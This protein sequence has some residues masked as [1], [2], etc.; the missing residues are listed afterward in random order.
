MS[1]IG[2]GIWA[3]QQAEI[4][5]LSDGEVR[6]LRQDVDKVLSPL[7]AMVVEEY[8][9][10]V[11]AA[12]AGLLAA[13]ASS[14]A[15]QTVLAAG[16]LAGGVAALLADGRNVTFTTAGATPAD[17]PATALITGTNMDGA[18]QTE[19]VNIAQTATIANGV[20]AFKTITSVVYSAGDGAA[21]TVS[22]GFGLKFGL[23]K[24]P[25]ARA[26]LT[27]AIRE[28]EV[29]VLVTTGTLDATNRTYLPATA[30][31]GTRDYCIYY[32]YDATTT[33]DG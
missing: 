27:S 28:I 21:A 12:A 15:V 20:K 14:I 24:K 23:G 7:A 19:T 26:G 29:G 17:A 5:H 11:A 31:D 13:T 10:P 33:T 3:K 6:D 8:T 1:T 16:L 9:N 25:K 4:P 22:I 2:S 18:A 30:P 32:E